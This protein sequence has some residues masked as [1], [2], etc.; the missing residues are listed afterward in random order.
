MAQPCKAA[1]VA[2]VGLGHLLDN[3]EDSQRSSSLS[4]RFHRVPVNGCRQIFAPRLLITRSNPSPKGA[5]TATKMGWAGPPG[6]A[7][8][9]AFWPVSGPSFAGGL[10]LQL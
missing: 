7:G 10:L 8:L 1:V 5:R 9:G 2:R 4:P 3:F 6:P